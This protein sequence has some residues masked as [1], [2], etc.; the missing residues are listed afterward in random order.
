MI[1]PI[2]LM[3]MVGFSVTVPSA[4]ADRFSDFLD[5]WKKAEEDRAIKYQ[6]KVL[7]FDYSKIQNKD[8]GFKSGVDSKDIPKKHIQ[9]EK[10]GVFKVIKNLNN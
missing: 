10:R 3:V 6:K 4:F 8:P 2:L 5:V 1:V 9:N 7:N